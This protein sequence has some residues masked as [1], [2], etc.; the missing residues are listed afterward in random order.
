VSPSVDP[1]I[2]LKVPGLLGLRHKRDHSQG[3]CDIPKAILPF[4]QNQEYLHP[5]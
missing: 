1:K 5:A 2:L 4:E 3:M